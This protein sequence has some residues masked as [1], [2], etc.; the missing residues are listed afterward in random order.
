M[1][2]SPSECQLAST[3]KLVTEKPKFSLPMTL[4]YCVYVKMH[5]FLALCWGCRNRS[6]PCLPAQVLNLE[7]SAYTIQ[8]R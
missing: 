3:S 1:G 2:F 4:Q 6:E 8:L 7:M 5:K